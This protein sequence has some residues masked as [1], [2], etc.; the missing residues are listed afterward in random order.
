MVVI[1]AII[2]IIAIVGIMY[3]VRNN[4]ELKKALTDCK[5]KLKRGGRES[6]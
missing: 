3:L 1:L 6:P 4:E 5:N 2:L